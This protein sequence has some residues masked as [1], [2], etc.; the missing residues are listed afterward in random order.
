LLGRFGVNQQG[1]EGLIVPEPGE[2]RL[3]AWSDQGYPFYSGQ[4]TY[5]KSVFLPDDRDIA[6]EIEEVDGCAQLFIDG[7]DA[8]VRLW[9]PWRWEVPKN[10][11]GKEVELVF[12]VTNTLANVLGEACRSGPKGR[13]RIKQYISN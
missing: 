1:Q 5:K 6:L 7:E 11:A 3:D 12:A 13:L 8:G 9:A 4:A 10:K 2:I